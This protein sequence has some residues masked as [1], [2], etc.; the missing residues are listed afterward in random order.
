MRETRASKRKR[1]Q[2]NVNELRQKT[3][4]LKPLKSRRVKKLT[5]KERIHKEAIDNEFMPDEIILATIP[6]FCCWPAR[7]LEIIGQTI[8][9]EFFGTGQ[10]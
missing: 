4:E 9:V 7:I 8:M 6:G 2:N 3:E 10:M 5:V 1:N